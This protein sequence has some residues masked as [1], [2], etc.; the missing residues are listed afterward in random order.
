MSGV[1]T[2]ILNSS[3]SPARSHAL[4][5]DPCAY[6]T[7]LDTFGLGLTASTPEARA[8]PNGEEEERESDPPSPSRRLAANEKPE[9]A[10]LSQSLGALASD[11]Q[12]YT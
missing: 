6:D 9:N 11:F 4:S 8:S 3:T 12:V 10:L 5:L 1:S 7:L 2:F